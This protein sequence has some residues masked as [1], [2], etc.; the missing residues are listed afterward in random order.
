MTSLTRAKNITRAAAIGLGVL[1]VVLIIGRIGLTLL[2]AITVEPRARQASLDQPDLAFGQIASPKLP[3]VNIDTASANIQLDLVS[4][5]FPQSTSSAAVYRVAESSLSLSA[6][7]RARATATNLGFTSEPQEPTPSSYK[8]QQG[9]RSLTLDLN[10]HTFDLTS[11]LGQIR[12]GNRQSFNRFTPLGRLSSQYIQSKFRYTDIQYDAPD[13]QFVIPTQDTFVP[14]SEN[15][16]S[17]SNYARISF[18]RRPVN[19]LPFYASSGKTGPISM[20]I[21]PDIV[22]DRQANA[23]LQS[24]QVIELHNNYLPIQL[25]KKGTYPIIPAQTAYQALQSE[26][27]R[28]IVSVIPVSNASKPTTLVNARVLFVSLVYLEPDSQ[29]SNYVQP[30]WMFEG[31]GQSDAGDNRWIAYVPA[32]NQAAVNSALSQ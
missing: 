6:R 10:N 31:R 27:K 17:P 8:W 25:D 15:A 2:D 16:V 12:F 20:I 4:G 5:N 11:D 1:A 23:G 22:R 29:N 21:I 19:D 32:I 28:Y 26:P 24:E 18:L 30:V 9:W 13:V 14:Q 7:D 3:L